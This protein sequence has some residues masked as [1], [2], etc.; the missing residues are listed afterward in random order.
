LAIAKLPHSK[1]RRFDVERWEAVVLTIA[2]TAGLRTPTW[3]LEARVGGRAVLV[4]ERFDRDDSGDRIGYMSARTALELGA[5]DEGASRTYEDFADAV[6]RWSTKPALDLREMFGRIALTVLINNVDDHWRN[7][8]FLHANDGWRLSP[9]F[10]VNPSRQRGVIDSR[11][12]NPD[13]DPGDRQLSHLIDSASVFRLRD[14]EARGIISHVA[15][16]VAGWETVARSLG[17]DVTQLDAYRSA[18]E[19]PQLDWASSAASRNGH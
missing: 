19:S 2:A 17:V 4:T 7:H 13:D 6:D 14:P 5:H 9:L 10:D 8:G 16:A 1:D 18:F 11:A 12:I 3:F 15:S